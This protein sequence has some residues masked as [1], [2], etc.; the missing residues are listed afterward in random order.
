MKA[1][2]PRDQ[3]AQT[4]LQ[5]VTEEDAEIQECQNPTKP[6]RVSW[7][8]DSINAIQTL[9]A[10]EIT[11][12][13]ITFTRVKEKIEGHPILSTEDPKRVYDKVRNWKAGAKKQQICQRNRKRS[14]T[15]LTEC[16]K[17]RNCT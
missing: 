6:Q 14:T 2:K 17:Q 9:F 11:A 8:E 4:S 7:K 16:F 3:R 13:N 1:V 10:E 5:E 12:Q 15:A